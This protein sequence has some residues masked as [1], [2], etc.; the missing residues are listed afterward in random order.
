MWYIVM[1][2]VHVPEYRCCGVNYVS[3]LFNMM[4][5]AAKNMIDSNN[6]GALKQAQEQNKS[7]TVL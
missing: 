5:I 3:T 1:S 6:G 4:K 7:M 2:I